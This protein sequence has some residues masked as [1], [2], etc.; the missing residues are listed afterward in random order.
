M[1]SLLYQKYQDLQNS[2]K[3]SWL[4]Y[5]QLYVDGVYASL[6]KMFLVVVF[7]QGFTDIYIISYDLRYSIHLFFSMRL[8]L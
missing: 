4:L 5:Y 3:A 7:V 1:E 8:G 2:F 6:R